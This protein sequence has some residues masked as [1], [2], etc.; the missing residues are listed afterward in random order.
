MKITELLGLF[1]QGKASAKSHMKDL[2]EMAAV[3]GDFDTEE[4][5]LLKKIGKQNGFS[6]SQ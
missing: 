2:I 5:E 3:D 6:E 4:F 1:R